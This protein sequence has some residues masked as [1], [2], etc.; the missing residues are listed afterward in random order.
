MTVCDGVV[1]SMVGAVRS[2]ACSS[3][4]PVHAQHSDNKKIPFHRRGEMKLRVVV[5]LL[6]CSYAASD[7]AAQSVL[8]RTPN[9]SG[10]WTGARNSIYFN[11]L[12]RFRYGDAPQ[13][14]VTN[15]PTFLLAYRA[16]VPVLVGFQYATRSDLV[17]LYPNEWEFFGRWGAL[18]QGSSGIADVSLQAA[19]N[20]AAESFDGE[21]SLARRFGRVRAFAAA[22]AFSSAYGTDDVRAALA[23]GATINVN[24][25]ITLAGDYAQL[26]DIEDS[27][28]GAWGAALQIAIPYT[29]H[30][31]SLQA[32][33]TNTA[34]L[35]GSSRGGNDVRWGFEFTIPVTLSRYFGS[36]GVANP[37][38][39]LDPNTP[40]VFTSARIGRF[41][42]MPPVIEV[43]AGASIVWFNE[44]PVPHT[45]TAADGSWNSGLIA[46]GATWRR[47]F[48][49]PGTYEYTCTPHPQMKGTIV[50]KPAS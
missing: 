17:A 47:T 50:V 13:R 9:L 23:G 32:T 26:L 7:A 48:E 34:S 41:A 39:V 28:D 20:L 43:T 24:E 29:P 46:P 8:E 42:Y 16:P 36:G 49:R 12:H 30:T 38:P 3:S 1:E 21:L 31:L 22:R 27:E 19:Y 33:N 10:G 37:P 40:D 6:L 35:Q 18:T 4:A 2:A 15:Y 45:V 44:D 14:Q 5:T 25:H 11:F